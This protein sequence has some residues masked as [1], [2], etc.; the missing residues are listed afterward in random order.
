MIW[1]VNFNCFLFCTSISCKCTT[2]P[3]SANWDLVVESINTVPRTRAWNIP[4]DAGKFSF[5]LQRMNSSTVKIPMRITIGTQIPQDSPIQ[6]DFNVI[7]Q[8]PTL[9]STGFAIYKC[10]S[11]SNSKPKVYYKKDSTNN[12]CYVTIEMT[13]QT[14]MWGRAFMEWYSYDLELTTTGAVDLSS[15]TA[16]SQ[17]NI[18]APTMELL[19]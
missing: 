3:V 11:V 8:E 16:A 12:R 9:S 10:L 5:V 2:V 18:Y 13:G 15:D 14:T 1:S 6:I 4:T 7:L 17:M 19:S